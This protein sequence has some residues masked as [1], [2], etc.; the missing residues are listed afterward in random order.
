MSAEKPIDGT[1]TTKDMPA[2]GPR[3]SDQP[4]KH[5][6]S[7]VG[8]YS[9]LGVLA[10]LIGAFA[11]LWTPLRVRYWEWEMRRHSTALEEEEKRAGITANLTKTFP[12]HA[13][14][15]DAQP[16]KRYQFLF[17]AR[18]GWSNGHTGNGG[19]YAWISPIA[20]EGYR[21]GLDAALKDVEALPLDM[22]QS[23]EKVKAE[24]PKP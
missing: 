7:L 12:I 13:T 10:L 4:A 15:Y 20:E 9:A 17:A 18:S 24:A 2:V 14:P 11:I 21:A 16:Q 3:P 22:K 1:A 19:T 6:R 8:F 5:E 23:T